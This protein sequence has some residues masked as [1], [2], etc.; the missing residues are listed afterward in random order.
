M[1][2]TVWTIFFLS[3]V[4][5]LEECSKT[6]VEPKDTAHRLI[7][8]R[9]RLHERASCSRK[10]RSCQRVS[11]FRICMGRINSRITRPSLGAKKRKKQIK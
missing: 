4:S 6:R 11:R 1:F 7:F 10:K 8:A 5:L 9:R 3:G 2:R